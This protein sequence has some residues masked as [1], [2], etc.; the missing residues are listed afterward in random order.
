MEIDRPAN[1]FLSTAQI[2]ATPSTATVGNA[3]G[4]WDTYRQRFYFNVKMRQLLGDLWRDYDTFVIS[5][6]NITSISQ[7]TL[8]ASNLNAQINIGGLNWR[9]S[10]Y[11]QITQA[12]NYYAPLCYLQLVASANG[13]TEKVFA[14]NSCCLTFNKGDTDPRIEFEVRNATDPN[15]FLTSNATNYLPTF[16]FLFDISPVKKEGQK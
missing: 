1:L 14:E 16:S 6:T 11:N 15:S 7:V 8:G 5:L 9:N 2:S 10:S 4:G 12:N 3:V 13:V